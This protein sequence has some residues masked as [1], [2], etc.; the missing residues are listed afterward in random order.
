MQETL[1]ALAKK[2]GIEL[3]DENVTDENVTETG[4]TVARVL[5][6]SLPQLGPKHLRRLAL[7]FRAMA[8]EFDLFAA[9]V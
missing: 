5:Y 7:V 1:N 4:I 8:D 2:L 9:C 6:T 3:T